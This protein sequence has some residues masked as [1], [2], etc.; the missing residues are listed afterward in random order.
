MLRENTFFAS[1][2]KTSDRKEASR[3]AKK[4]VEDSNGGDQKRRLHLGKLSEY[5]DAVGKG[6]TG[7]GMDY[8]YYWLYK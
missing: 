2:G 4:Q 7:R 1:A 3:Y 8:R 6:C 5:V